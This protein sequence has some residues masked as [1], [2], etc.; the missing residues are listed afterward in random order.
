[1]SAGEL[2][3]VVAVVLCA[4]GFAAL[5]VTLMRLLDAVREMRL[6]VER[7]NSEIG[8]LVDELRRSVVDARVSVAEAREDLDRFDRVLGSAE[9]ITEAVSGSSRLV[10]GALSTPVIKT[11][12][13]ASGTAEGVRR[14]RRKDRKAERNRGR[15]S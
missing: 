2:A 15:A 4:I 6:Q 7:M 12:A 11:V 8:P 5:V 1:M 13:L 10:R 9:A 14:L 3:V